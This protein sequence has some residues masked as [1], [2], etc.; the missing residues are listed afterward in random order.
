[1]ND[2]IL[3]EELTLGGC[4]TD[5]AEANFRAFAPGF[6]SL[7]LLEAAIVSLTVWTAYRQWR[8]CRDLTL[9]VVF[10]TLYLDGEPPCHC[11]C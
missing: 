9:S 4:M 5:P 1:M 2:V 10:K 7:L 3:V 11:Q 8:E 6:I